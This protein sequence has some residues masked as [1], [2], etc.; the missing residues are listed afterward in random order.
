M[1]LG[2]GA[3]PV[4]Q[5][6]VALEPGTMVIVQK[7]PFAASSTPTAHALTCDV[8]TVVSDGKAGDGALIDAI[9]TSLPDLFV[10]A[11]VL[12]APFPS[13]ER[14]RFDGLAVSTDSG[15]AE[16][17]KAEGPVPVVFLAT[18]VNV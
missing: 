8:L 11:M 13:P 18:T 2:V 10:M 6:E 3:I 7:P 5:A 9:V 14:A 12:A 15:A 4:V 16:L 1:T 17:E